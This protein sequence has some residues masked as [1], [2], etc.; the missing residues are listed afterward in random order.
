[1]TLDFKL[2]KSG[3]HKSIYLQCNNKVDKQ[4]FSLRIPIRISEQ[5]WDFIKQRPKDIYKKRFKTINK[6]L[7]LIK[8]HLCE[9][10]NKLEAKKKNFLS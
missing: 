9:Y 7:N 4:N 2:S 10:I 5:D 6:K 3:T 1:M 8:V